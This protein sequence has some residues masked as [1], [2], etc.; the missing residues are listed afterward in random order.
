MNIKKIAASFLA[1]AMTMCSIASGSLAADIG[2]ADGTLDETTG[3]LYI[4]KD[5]G[6][7]RVTYPDGTWPKGDI[8]IPETFGDGENAKTVTE[9]S[10]ELIYDAGYA[11]SISI[12]ATITVI[13][14]SHIYAHEPK[15]QSITVA[16]DNPSYSSV[17]GVLFNKDKTELLKYPAK[18]EC[19]SYVVPSTVTKIHDFGFSGSEISSIELPNGLKYLGSDAFASCK[20]LKEVSLPGSL[21]YIGSGLF[22]DAGVS[23]VTIDPSCSNY[24]VIDNVLFTAD[25]KTLVAYPP[26]LTAEKYSVPEGT[27]VLGFDTFSGNRNL[28]EIKLPD[29]IKEIGRAFAFVSNLTSIKIPKG[30]TYIETQCF[31]MCTSLESV[32]I[33]VTV[34]KIMEAAFSCCNALKTINYGGTQ[35][36]WDKIVIES[37]NEA[38]NNATIK[39]SDGTTGD[40][41]LSDVAQEP[42]R[43]DSEDGKTVDFTPGVKKN[44]TTSDNDI[45]T[46]KK[47]KAT[48]PKEAFDEDVMLN[49]SHDN[50]SPD[51]DSFAVDISFVNSDGT[52]VQPKEGAKVTVKIPVPE[53]LKDKENIFV[54]HINKDGKAEKI[55]A[56]TETID[57]IKYM[58]FEA[59]NFSTYVLSEKSDLAED[60]EPN[61]PTP[62]T[63]DTPVTP[64]TPTTIGSVS[65]DNTTSDATSSETT[66]T[67]TASSEPV[68]T[69]SGN[70]ASSNTT[71]EPTSATNAASDGNP[72]TGIA[73]SFIPIAAAVSAVIVIKRRK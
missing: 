28:K 29:S 52:K 70:S 36:D 35:A 18:K 60:N 14:D 51:K 38:L 16:E 4:E 53:I 41:D 21:E 69:E 66:S 42:A 8:I 32:D 49:V 50:F 15:M 54:Y 61:D 19:A 23:S 63:P 62:D 59:S 71:S 30:V 20:N 73:F 22:Y 10:G 27:E 31:L 5:D 46:M 2:V 11:L 68:S 65:F 55:E 64:D 44:I 33:P 39:F 17:D 34:T 67:E 7:L 13:D 72:G 40:T 58:V 9:M 37:G 6:T 3:L 24:C 43:T 47:V 56:T 45:E 57:N 25:K 26:A 12:P 1:A 48:A